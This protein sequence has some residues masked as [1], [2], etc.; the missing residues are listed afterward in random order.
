MADVF[1]NL[2]RDYKIAGNIRYYITDNMELNNIYI[3][4]ILYTLYLNILI[5]LYKKH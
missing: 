4:I 5:K 3:N 1:I 2:F